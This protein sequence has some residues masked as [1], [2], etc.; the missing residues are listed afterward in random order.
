MR[1]RPA[2]RLSSFGYSEKVKDSL[3][4]ELLTPENANDI[5]IPDGHLTLDFYKYLEG[6]T[7]Y[8]L[9][10][11]SRWLF[12]RHLFNGGSGGGVSRGAAEILYSETVDAGNVGTGEDNLMSYAIPAD[13]LANNN[14]YIKFK[15]VFE[16][17]ANGN[18][19]RLR[20]YLG[21]SVLLD[22]GALALNNNELT[23]EGTIWRVSSTT[24][25]ALTIS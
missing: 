4:P 14:E 11:E 2:R 25:R 9:A 7:P 12:G 16:T 6:D 15:G 20:A 19:K 8:N 10:D 23:V 17:A 5:A 21:T 18:N 13:T 22:T 1:T 24:F 3:S